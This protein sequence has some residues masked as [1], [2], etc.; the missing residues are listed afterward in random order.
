MPHQHTEG[1]GGR[2][3]AGPTRAKFKNTDF[4]DMMISTVLCDLCFSLNHPLKSAVD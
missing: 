3:A 2:G 1:R 4:V